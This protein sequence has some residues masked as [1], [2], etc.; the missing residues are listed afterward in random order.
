LHSMLWYNA[1][2]LS[3]AC[4]PA[5]AQIESGYAAATLRNFAMSDLRLWRTL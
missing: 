2:M 3:A 1:C 4:R 5:W